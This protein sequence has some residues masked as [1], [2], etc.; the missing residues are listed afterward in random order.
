MS[1]LLQTRI[2]VVV[3]DITRLDVDGVVTAANQ[4]LR[5]GGGVDGA[6]HA[7]AG[8]ELV[9][10]SQPLAPCP[11]GSAKIT[12]GFN[13]S[14]DFVIHAVGP[15]FRDLQ[16]DSATLR[17]TYRSALALAAEHQI[18]RVAFPCI[19][20]GVY[21]FP[22]RPACDIATATVIQWLQEQAA[23]ELVVFCCFSHNDGDLYRRRL[24]ELGIAPV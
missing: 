19:S 8:P 24:Q 13:L 9:A 17:S 12:P 6:V 15:V 3:D 14:A 16:A 1:N 23:P 22:G 5:G 2:Q 21:G 7:A 10:A 20:T 18:N 4:S 11:A